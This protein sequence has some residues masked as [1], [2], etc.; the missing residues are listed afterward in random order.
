MRFSV[1]TAYLNGSGFLVGRVVSGRGMHL[2]RRVTETSTL[3][4]GGSCYTSQSEHAYGLPDFARAL[5]IHI[6]LGNS[7][8]TRILTCGL[9]SCHL[10]MV[11]R[12][13]PSENQD[14]SFPREYLKS[15]QPVR[16][17]SKQIKDV[18]KVSRKEVRSG[19]A[20][21]GC[22]GSLVFYK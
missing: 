3:W 18:T 5:I 4:P 15:A 14:F 7:T 21:T 17:K 12:E 19:R 22:H 2:Y 8:N 6:T 9:D 20:G 11:S 10:S 13:K 1:H 16:I